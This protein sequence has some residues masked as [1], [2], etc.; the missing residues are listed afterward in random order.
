MREL[1][2]VIF[3]EILPLLFNVYAENKRYIYRKKGFCLSEDPCLLYAL[4]LSL[5]IDLAIELSKNY[6]NNNEHSC[7]QLV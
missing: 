3:N 6:N 7:L 4:K 2:I 1:H 5:H